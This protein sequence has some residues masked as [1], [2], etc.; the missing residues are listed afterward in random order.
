M[1]SLFWFSLITCS[2]FEG[3]ATHWSP[4]MLIISLVPAG[5]QFSASLPVSWIIVIQTLCWNTLQLFGPSHPRPPSRKT[6]VI[7]L[8]IWELP[9]SFLQL[10]GLHKLKND[11]SFS[12]LETVIHAFIS[13]RL[14]DCNAVHAGIHQSSL[15]RHV[16]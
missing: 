1:F 13:S 10:R 16:S 2:S 8:K 7:K 5:V 11:L 9:L 12:D 14:D 15:S 6:F 3:P 4:W